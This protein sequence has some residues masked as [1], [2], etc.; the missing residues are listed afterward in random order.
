MS[1]YCGIDLHSNNSYVVVLDEED[2]AHYERR[3]PND[4]AVIEA[5]LS[6]FAGDLSGVVVE[7][8]YNWYWLVDG[9]MASDYRVHLAH[10][11]KMQQYDG[12]K[13]SDDRVNGGVK[14]GHV[15]A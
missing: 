1:Y 7:S 6:R 9:L 3:L 5:S 2:R 15:A 11:A 8:T 10:P 13:Y 4:L 14:T 12:L